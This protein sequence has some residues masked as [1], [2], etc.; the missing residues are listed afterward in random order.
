MTS[1]RKP[2]VVMRAAE[3]EAQAVDFVHPWNPTSSLR[4]AFLARPAGLKRT[5]IN[6]IRLRAGNQSFTYHAHLHEEEWIY[7]VAGNAV[8]ESGGVRHDVGAGDFVAFPT[9]S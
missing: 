3:I 2:A 4:G 5:G 8:L 7:L 9:P 1:E 6:L